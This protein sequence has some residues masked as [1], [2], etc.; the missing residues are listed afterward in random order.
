MILVLDIK[1]LLGKLRRGRD[2]CD[3]T[4]KPNTI[5]IHKGNS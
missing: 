1:G 2:S 5:Y 3:I 4:A